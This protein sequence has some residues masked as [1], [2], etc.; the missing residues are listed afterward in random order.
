[1]SE[2]YYWDSPQLSDGDFP[3][4][5]KTKFQVGDKAKQ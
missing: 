1:M 2:N 4:E 5:K 3:Q